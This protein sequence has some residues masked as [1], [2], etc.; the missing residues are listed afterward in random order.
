MK[1]DAQM[2]DSTVYE[3]C[4]NVFIDVGFDPAEAAVLALRADLMIKIEQRLRD[5]KL[6]QVEAAKLLGISQARV[7]DL[8]NGKFNKFSLDMLAK[9]AE[10]IGLHC[11]LMAA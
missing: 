6:T 9:L 2:S 8:L 5:Q 11:T 4:G 10:R 7:S 3:S 1:T